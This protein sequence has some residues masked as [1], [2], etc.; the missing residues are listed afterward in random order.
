MPFEVCEGKGKAKV[1]EEE[2]DGA[3]EMDELES[4]EVVLVT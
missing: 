2:G 3:T 4:T 1:G